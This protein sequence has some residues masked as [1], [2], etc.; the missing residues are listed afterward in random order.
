MDN[1]VGR[2]GHLAGF[3]GF[4]SGYPDPCCELVDNAPVGL[5]ETDEKGN[6]SFVNRKWQEIA[7]LS[8]EEAVGSG[9]VNGI[10]AEDRDLVNTAWYKSAN[11]G[12][13]FSL[14]YRF[15]TPNHKVTWVRGNSH[16]IKISNNILGFIG[17]I[18]DISDQVAAESLL[19]DNY[20]Q[21]ESLVKAMVDREERI[22]E[23]KREIKR[24]EEENALLRKQ[25][26]AL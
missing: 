10:H 25:G 4:N 15:E 3:T 22:I 24:L 17:S 13:P 6:C 21:A 2:K 23:L 9:W 1:K 19:N 11:L 12:L 7:G 20:Q 18:V 16:A 14:N 26:D 8:L 5:F